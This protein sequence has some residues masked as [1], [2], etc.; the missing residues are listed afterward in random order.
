M[1]IKGIDFH[2]SHFFRAIFWEN[3]V[4]PIMILIDVCIYMKKVT[5][6]YAIFVYKNKKNGLHWLISFNSIIVINFHMY[7]FLMKG[8]SK[9]TKMIK[10]RQWSKGIV[11]KKV[12]TTNGIIRVKDG[13]LE[14][15]A[16]VLIWYKY[17]KMKGGFHST[18]NLLLPLVYHF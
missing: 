9:I 17:F 10:F 13:K 8:I 14:T 3:F 7:F 12:C 18:L 5:L 1:K 4:N 6:S 11:K 2:G 16:K 15:T